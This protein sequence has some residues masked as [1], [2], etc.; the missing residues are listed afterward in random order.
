[1]NKKKK[2]ALVALLAFLGVVALGLGAFVYAKYISTVNGAA[3]AQVAH[4]AFRTE[5]N[6]KTDLI[7]C[8][9]AKTYDPATLVNGKMAP[10]TEGKCTIKVRNTESEVGV[11]YT[12]V[13]AATGKPTN[14]KF[15]EDAAHNTPLAAAGV[16]GHLDAGATDPDTNIIYWY[17]PYETDNGDGDG[18][19]TSEGEA[20]GTM[21]I[22]FAITG[23]Q[24]QPAEQ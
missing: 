21:A 15:Y 12:I 4:W 13:V 2:T 1:M 20:A 11:D 6:G 10:G 19:D 16:T 3:E 24:V 8:E 17:W 9:P 18:I 23:V 7:K 22:D 14:L 5:N